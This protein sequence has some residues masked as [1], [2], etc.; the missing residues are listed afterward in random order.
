[1]PLPSAQYSSCSFHLTALFLIEDKHETP[2]ESEDIFLISYSIYF[3]TQRACYLEER[4]KYFSHIEMYNRFPKVSLI[5]IPTQSYLVVRRQMHI[6]P[7]TQI[8]LLIQLFIMVTA[9]TCQSHS[10][11]S[12]I[13]FGIEWKCHNNNMPACPDFKISSEVPGETNM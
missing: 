1:M 5:Q 13:L 3:A 8:I 12:P 4:K 11:K 2:A 7:V 6:K 9:I 10:G